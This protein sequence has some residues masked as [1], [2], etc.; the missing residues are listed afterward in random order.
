VR[1]GGSELSVCIKDYS[2]LENIVERV[3]P[4]L[5]DYRFNPIPA[6]VIL[7]IERAGSPRQEHG[8]VLNLP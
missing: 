4:L 2:R 6:R 7:D 3:D 1:T 8:E 5:T